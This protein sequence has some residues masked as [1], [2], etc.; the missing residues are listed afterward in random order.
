MRLGAITLAVFVCLAAAEASAQTC[1]GLPS[2]SE[3]PY[4]ASGGAG[5]TDGAQ[6]FGGGMAVGSSDYFAGLALFFTNFSD[7]DS[8][9]TT[10]AFNVGASYPISQQERIEVCP[11]AAVNVTTGPDVGE[12]D[13]SG[14]GLR[15]GGRLG[16]VAAQAGNI[17]IV[18]TFGLD[19]AYDRVTADVGEVDTS[20]SETY[21]IVRVGLGLV[22]NKKIGVVSTLGVPLGLEGSDPEFSILA[23]FTFG[24][25]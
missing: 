4:Q 21:S 16:L 25:R 12:A 11:V 17:D 22:F 19:I 15:G 24:N 1:V 8:G 13:I 20:T 7:V 14:V 6:R 10:V 23:S 18:P 3:G 5:F 2:F 9:A